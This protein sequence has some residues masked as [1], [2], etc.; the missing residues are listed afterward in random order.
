[1]KICIGTILTILFMVGTSCEQAVNVEKEKE[2]ILAVLHAEGAA[3]IAK[4]MEGVFALHVK[5]ELETRLEM[6]LYGYNKY[7]G[8]EEVE[9]LLSDFMGG[10]G[11]I[12]GVEDLKNTKENV[13]MKVTGNTA[14]LTCDNI[15]EWTTDGVKDGYTNLQIVFFE[16]I[17]GEWKISFAAYYGKPKP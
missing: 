5:D 15:L 13:V 9:K 17:K 11:E 12:G 16:K 3:A 2:A 4:D 7:E 14:W 10:E 6:G 1:M 8:W